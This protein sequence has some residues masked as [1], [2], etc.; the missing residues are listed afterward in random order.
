[1]LIGIRQQCEETRTLDSCRQLAL[2]M[3]PGTRNA[4]RYYLTRLTHV[5]L[6]RY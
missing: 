3:R 2:I 4:A 6:Q 5:S 1:M